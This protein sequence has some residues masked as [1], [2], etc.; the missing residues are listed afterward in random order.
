MKTRLLA[1][2]QPSSSIYRVSLESVP[3]RHYRRP[4]RYEKGAGLIGLIHQCSSFVFGFQ[5]IFLNNLQG[6]GQR[7]FPTSIKHQNFFRM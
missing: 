2:Y 5:I 6:F 7:F 3:Q 4:N 1:K